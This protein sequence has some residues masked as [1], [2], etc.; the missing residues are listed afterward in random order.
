MKAPIGQ[1]YG[2]QV[3]SVITPP[4]QSDY[5]SQ[6]TTTPQRVLESKTTEGG[7]KGNG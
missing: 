4:I 2:A 3:S 1:A 5:M 6:I 7:T